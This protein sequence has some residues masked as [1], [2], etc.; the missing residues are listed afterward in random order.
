MVTGAGDIAAQLDGMTD[1][2][3]S[4]GKRGPSSQLN[5]MNWLF[6]ELVKDLSWEVS[7]GVGN[8]AAA[9][10]AL[11]DADEASKQALEKIARE[12]TEGSGRDPWT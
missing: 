4:M 11:L 6:C 5:S 10:T 7:T 9:V 2:L 3:D 8:R 12:A 1:N